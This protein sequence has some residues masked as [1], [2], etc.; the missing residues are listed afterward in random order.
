MIGL[1][2][3]VPLE[4]FSLYVSYI[5]PQDGVAIMGIILPLITH[6]S[7]IFMA[8]NLE[9]RLFA[10]SQ[11]IINSSPSVVFDRFGIYYFQYV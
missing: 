7:L 11:S 4:Q 6:M 9:R 10:T 5:V 8:Q 1:D 2:L 3:N